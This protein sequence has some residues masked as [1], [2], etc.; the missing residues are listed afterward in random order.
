MSNMMLPIGTL[1][2]L[3]K[4]SLQSTKCLAGEFDFITAAEEWK[5]HTEYSHECEALVFAGSASGSLGRTHYVDGKFTSSDLC[6]I[7]TPKDDNK[8]PLNLSFYHFVF[9]S[10][11]PVL[12]SATKSGTSKESINQK[13]FKKYKIP[14][15]DIDQQEFWIGKLKST[16]RIKDLLD[17][18]LVHQRG[19]LKE[20]R[21]QILQEAIEGKLTT[22][23][24]ATSQKVEPVSK[25][26][27]DIAAEKADLIK[28]KKMKKQKPLLAI[29][30]EEKPF[31][32]PKSWKW[33]R[34]GELLY[35]NPR[36]GYSPKTVDFETQTKTLKLGAT[37]SGSF[38][39]SQIKYIDEDIPEDSHLWL[40]RGDILIQRSNSLEHVGVSAI[41]TGE[42]YEFIYPDLMMKLRFAKQLSLKYLHYVLTSPFSR[43]YFRSN[44]TGAQKSMPKINQGIVANALIPLPPRIDQDEIVSKLES[45]LDIC[46]ALS[47]EIVENSRRT[48]TLIGTLSWETFSNSI[49]I[50]AGRGNEHV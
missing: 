30:D 47:T 44:A 27:E 50:A 3:E 25:L 2:D 17:C 7:L 39:C 4:G 6:F 8:Y 28:V 26:L 21:Q 31:E 15:L 1:F 32:L 45:Q 38:D 37:T 10:L 23:W 22:D 48:S 11:R 13:N 33:C 20:L 43:K 42:D 46:K 36:N 19:L 5:T 12:V 41:Y 14:Y 18:E 34:L 9:N 40:E 24:R 49:P 29:S 16:L 35:E